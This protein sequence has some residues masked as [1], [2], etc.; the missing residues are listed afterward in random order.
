MLI[1]SESNIEQTFLFPNSQIAFSISKNLEKEFINLEWDGCNGVNILF[2]KG[3]DYLFSEFIESTPVF[4]TVVALENTEYCRKYD[5]CDKKTICPASDIPEQE[6]QPFLR[7]SDCEDILGIDDLPVFDELPFFTLFNE[8]HVLFGYKPTNE[9]I[10]KAY[11]TEWRDVS[12]RK[13]IFLDI[14]NQPERFVCLGANGLELIGGSD[15]C[16]QKTESNPRREFF[17]TSL[18]SLGRKFGQN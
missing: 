9:D 10:L 17:E 4:Q 3:E 8:T 13:S 16:N 1:M 12:R 2:D 6:F 18:F 14:K 11:Q 5:R 7:E 15:T